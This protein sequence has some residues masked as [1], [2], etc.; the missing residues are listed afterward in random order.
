MPRWPVVLIV[1]LV[2]ASAILYGTRLDYAPQFMM[3]DELQFALQAESIATTGRDLSGRLLPVFFTEPEFPAGRDPVIIYATAL[4]LKWLPFSETSA[5]MATALTGVVSVALMFLLARRLFAS[6]LVGLG[7]AGLLALTPA[8]FIRSRLALS[9]QYA[10]PFVLAWL[11]A[12]VLF[13]ERPSSRRLAAAAAWLGVG[14]YTY[15]ASVVMMPVYLMLTIWLAH[16]VWGQRAAVVA[17]VAF[18]VPLI[19]MAAWYVAYPERTSQILESYRLYGAAASNSAPEVTA[20]FA[21]ARLRVGLLW[22]FF[23][24]DFLFVT[25]DSSLVNST[26]QIGFFPLSFAVLLPVGV[27]RLMT[28]QQPVARII[29]I[30]LATAPFAA[31]L[32]GA[33][34]MN[35]IQLAI[36]FGVLVATYGM[37]ALATARSWVWRAVAVGLVASVPMQFTGFYQDYMGRH[38]VQSSAWFGGNT[39]EIFT[40]AIRQAD[41]DPP[42]RVY[43]SDAIPFAERYW[44]FYALTEGRRDVI[45]RFARYGPGLPTAAAAGSLLVCP[46]ASV[47]CQGLL[48]GDSSWRTLKIVSEL[49]G[50]PSFALFGQH[51]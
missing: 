47:E 49:D 29:L 4:L 51:R 15:L 44:R 1:A 42:Q 40:A 46:L 43:V 21:A 14:A 50:S 13:S 3:H 6:D 12:L 31:I 5:R 9:P 23:S 33:L 32:T 41:T 2:V 20:I 37:V 8:H 30:G 16:R 38:R 17:G 28:T 19:P 7:A 35:R 48:T 39:R 11:L 27:Y 24:P 18:L 36:P 26:R 25:G 45:E 10:I 34:E 22:S